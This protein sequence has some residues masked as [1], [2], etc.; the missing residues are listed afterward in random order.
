MDSIR[1]ASRPDGL[2][3]LNDVSSRSRGGEML[4]EFS[5][6][7]SVNGRE[8]SVGNRLGSGTEFGRANGINQ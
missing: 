3:S 6:R 5:W 2:V 7:E 8:N 1:H 4:G